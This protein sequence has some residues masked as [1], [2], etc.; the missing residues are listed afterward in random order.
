MTIEWKFPPSPG[1]MDRASGIYLQNMTG[2]QVEERLKENDILIVPIGSTENHGRGQCSGED[3]FLVSRMAEALAQERG[4]TVAQPLWY[5]SH[6]WH[7]L[8]MPGTVVIPED[9]FVA[10]LRAMIAGFWNTGFRKQIFLN[11]HGQEYV[12]PTALH[13]FAKTYQVPCVLSFVNWPTVIKDHMKDKE[14]G[15]P[16]ETK[17]RHADEAEASYSLALFPEM[18]SME[19]MEDHIPEEG[20]A[21]EYVDKGGD[22]YQSPIPGHCQV[23]L[24]GGL[25]AITCPEGVIGQPTLA[26]ADKAKEGLKELLNFLVRLHDDIL[27]NYPPGKLPPAGKMSQR[28]QEEIDALLKGPLNGGKH[29]YTFQYPP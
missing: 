12:I 13:Q 24:G 6:P 14:H 4:C 18:N 20:F 16:F 26:S 7:H 27:T 11:G 21:S 25:E 28:S 1:H 22:V 5:G 8:G 3:T 10:Y 19:D 9:V 23:G 17:F 15:G 29:I 2:K